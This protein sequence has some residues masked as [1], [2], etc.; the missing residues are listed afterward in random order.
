M[1]QSALRRHSL[2]EILDLPCFDWTLLPDLRE[3]PGYP[4]ILASPEGFI[5]SKRMR[6]P[7]RPFN[8]GDGYRSLSMRTP[9][10]RKRVYAHVLIC[11]AFHGPA[12]S[13]NSVVMHLNSVRHDN[14]DVNL[15]WGSQS[16]NILQAAEEG[17]L[18]KG[19][20]RFA[21]RLTEDQ[22]REIRLHPTASKK[23]LARQH[24]V[25]PATI[26]SVRDRRTWRWIE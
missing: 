15:R 18:L 14:R 17:K 16:Q 9:A 5:V 10:G 6:Q 1:S 7:L 22:V 8:A 23:S 24:G 12:P 11:R 4:D 19:P 25:S 21:T 2:Y 13:S 3:V 20:K 26:G